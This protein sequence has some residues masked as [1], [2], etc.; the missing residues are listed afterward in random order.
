MEEQEGMIKELK[1]TVEDHQRAIV[2][3]YA[4]VE[5]FNRT[6]MEQRKTIQQLQKT[7]EDQQLIIVKLNGTDVELRE[8]M[9]DQR[10]LILQVNE[11]SQSRMG[12]IIINNK[13]GSFILNKYTRHIS[14][15]LINIYV[16]LPL[17][18]QNRKKMEFPT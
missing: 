18:V 2:Q 14:N 15:F 8:E 7:T 13:L 5:V 11:S 10:Q 9:D 17:H 16:S 3:S 4:L 1:K 12:L 6:I